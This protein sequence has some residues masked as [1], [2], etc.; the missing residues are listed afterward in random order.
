M[1][2][3]FFL[4]AHR[5]VGVL[6][7]GD[8]CG[9]PHEHKRHLLDV[10]VARVEHAVQL[11]QRRAAEKEQRQHDEMMPP[12]EEWHDEVAGMACIYAQVLCVVMMWTWG[13]R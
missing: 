6:Q 12:D 3:V 1:A 10:R 8:R 4:G 5:R 7:A 13:V 9:E 11:N 2:V